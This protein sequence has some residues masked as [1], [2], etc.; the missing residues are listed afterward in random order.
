MSNIMYYDNRTHCAKTATHAR[1]NEGMN[2]MDNPPPNV[3]QLK[4][5]IGT[6]Y[7]SETNEDTPS[8]NLN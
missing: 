4:Q 8:T 2:D 5:A 7:P 1:F 6:P 3:L